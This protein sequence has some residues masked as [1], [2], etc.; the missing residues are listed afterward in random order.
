MTL[1]MTALYSAYRDSSPDCAL[2][3]KDTQLINWRCYTTML[4]DALPN[5]IINGQSNYSGVEAIGTVY[6]LIINKRFLV[7]EKYGSKS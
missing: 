1:T 2:A 3:T 6:L 4:D 5:E 7:L